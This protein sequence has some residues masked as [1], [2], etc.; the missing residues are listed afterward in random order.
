MDIRTLV[1][2]MQSTSVGTRLARNAAAQFGTRTRRYIGAEILP[3]RLVTENAYREEQVRYRSVIANAGTRYSPT[4][5]KKGV[6]VGSIDVI[7]AESDIASELTSRDYDALRRVLQNAGSMEATAQM[8]RF[9]DTTVNTPLVELLEKWRWQ[10]IVDALITARGDNDY[11]EDFAYANPAGHRTAAAAAWSTDTTDIWEEIL[12][13]AQL[14][15]SKGYEV[16]RIVTGSDVIS[17]MSGNNTIKSRA[18]RITV[19]NTGQI[20]AQF[21]RASRE[22]INAIAREDNLPPFET[23]DL[24][25]RTSTGTGYFFP[26]G[27]M[28]FLGTSGLSEEIDL[29][30]AGIELLDNTLGYTA[31]GVAA[32]QNAP[33]RIIRMEAFENKPPRIEA[34]GWQTAVP[35]ILEPEAI[36]VINTIT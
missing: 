25:Y 13:R 21:G 9:L 23:Y 10:A 33:G 6:L 18:G 32:G 8:I 34:E 4:Q 12:G 22:D 14:L 3:E 29:G 24:M 26:R 17:I 7:L 19:N 16:N 30:D 15:R 28:V 27:T 11:K 2:Q 5:K 20:T 31:V 1:A 35:L 36:G